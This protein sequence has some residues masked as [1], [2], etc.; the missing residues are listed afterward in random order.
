MRFSSE[1]MI[2]SLQLNVESILEK[3][4]QGQ[5]MPSWLWWPSSQHFPQT[6]SFFVLVLQNKVLLP[7]PSLSLATQKNP[8]IACFVNVLSKNTYRFNFYKEPMSPCC[9]PGI[10][11]HSYSNFL[12]F[13]FQKSC[14]GHMVVQGLNYLNTCD[15][16]DG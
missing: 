2:I 8:R 9:S 10:S 11:Q 4:H 12:T 13:Q 5:H 16:L 14:G 6:N 7:P 1:T 15:T 3:G